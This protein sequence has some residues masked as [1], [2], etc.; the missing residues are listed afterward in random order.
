MRH[1][2]D[3]IEARFTVGIEQVGGTDMACLEE[4]IDRRLSLLQ[5]DG[6][7]A[8]SLHFGDL[9]SE[10]NTPTFPISRQ[11][12]LPPNHA[13]PLSPCLSFTLMQHDSHDGPLANHMDF[14]PQL[15]QSSYP[16]MGFEGEAG[17]R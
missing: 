4:H 9:L 1:L 5:F 16:V 11:T 13:T 17:V 12:A 8:C 15:S 7:C 10:F 6:F 14:M 3:W 2:Q